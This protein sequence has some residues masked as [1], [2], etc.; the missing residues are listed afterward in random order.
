MLPHE[1][2]HFDRF[3]F[4]TCALGL[5]GIAVLVL[6]DT[7]TEVH[8]TVGDPVRAAGIVGVLAVAATVGL[9][10]TIAVVWA[11]G[12][13]LLDFPDVAREWYDE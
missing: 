3:L 4:G 9:V 1:P 6:Y 11:A 10:I 7:Y 13:L 2:G 5:V 8:G 12:W